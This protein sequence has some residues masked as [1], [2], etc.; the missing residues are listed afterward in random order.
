MLKRFILTLFT[1]S[2]FGLAHLGIW[3]HPALASPVPQFSS[4]SRSSTLNTSQYLSSSTSDLGGDRLDTTFAQSH[5]LLTHIA[6]VS[7]NLYHLALMNQWH[8]AK[9]LVPPISK[10]VGNLSSRGFPDAEITQLQSY[11]SDLQGA[12]ATKNYQTIL[13][14]NQLSFLATGM[15]VQMDQSMPMEVVKLDYYAHELSPWVQIG[16]GATRI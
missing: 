6:M 14:A 9:S 13:D 11:V 10:L 7:R 4:V 3:S 5:A 2:L 1:I 8:E 12:I 15:A 16:K